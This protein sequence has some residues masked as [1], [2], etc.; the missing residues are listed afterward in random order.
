MPSAA[1]LGDI[2]DAC[3]LTAPAPIVSGVS[4]D[5]LIGG[6]PAAM[7]GASIANGSTVVM[8]SSGVLVNGMPLARQGDATT[9]GSIIGPGVPTVQ[10]N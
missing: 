9:C 3:P 6:L 2:G 5:V 10:V 8:G 1:V 7:M 4:P